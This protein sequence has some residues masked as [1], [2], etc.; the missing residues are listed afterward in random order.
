MA[1]AFD[2]QQTELK[3]RA[4]EDVVTRGVE[5]MERAMED[6]AQRVEESGRRVKHTIELA[7][8][9]GREFLK[10]KDN[11]VLAAQP[12]APY[13]RTAMSNGSRITHRVRANP[14]PLLWAV[15]GAFGGYLAWVIV[16]R[17]TK[18]LALPSADD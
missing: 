17:R 6:L 4:A 12:L 8:R 5:K 3:I 18:Q 15:A 7:R 11:V 1:N 10:I 9:S 14:R 16:N 13:L 2:E